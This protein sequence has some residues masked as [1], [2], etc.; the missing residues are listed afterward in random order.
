MIELIPVEFNVAG[1][2]MPPLLVAG[3]LG[4]LATV[5]TAKILT[6]R[7]LTRYLFY[8]P[9]AFVALTVVYSIAIE[10]FLAGL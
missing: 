4:L 2:Y 7:H 8:P 6:A 1:V 9:L 3:A 5:Q 10:V